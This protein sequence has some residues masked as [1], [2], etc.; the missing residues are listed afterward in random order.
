M[1]DKR[2]QSLAQAVAGIKD[3]STMLIG[4]FGTSG[5]PT[6]LLAAVLELGVNHL[7]GA[8]SAAGQKH[9]RGG[10]VH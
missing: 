10:V 5:R 8:H 1:I 4:G 9:G 6:E 2:V 3:G 7:L